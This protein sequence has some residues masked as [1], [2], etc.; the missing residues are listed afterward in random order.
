MQ[1]N[2]GAG[3]DRLT[4]DLHLIL[5]KLAQRFGLSH[6]LQ[7]SCINRERTFT[8]GDDLRLPFKERC[9]GFL[10]PSL[11]LS[12]RSLVS[13]EKRDGGRGGQ[14]KEAMHFLVGVSR[15]DVDIGILLGDFQLQAGF[16][17]SVLRKSAS[18]IQAV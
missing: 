14:R 3:T 17:S 16:G 18:N 9:R 13:I 6:F 7:R 1:S 4:R 5:L 8:S 2:V 15:P 11:G 12:D 10:A